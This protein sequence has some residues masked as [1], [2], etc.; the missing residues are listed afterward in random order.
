MAKKTLQRASGFSYYGIFE[1]YALAQKTHSK[2]HH[3]KG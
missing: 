1:K 2:L 3:L